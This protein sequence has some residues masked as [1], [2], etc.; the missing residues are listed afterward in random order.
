MALIEM[1]WQAP[2]TFAYG[3]SPGSKRLQTP[4]TYGI[5]PCLIST[6]PVLSFTWPKFFPGAIIETQ[7]QMS[8]LAPPAPPTPDVELGLQNAKPRAFFKI[9][10]ICIHAS[11]NPPLGHN[12]MLYRFC[13]I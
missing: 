1:F 8:L 4:S 3:S 12:T 10:Q 2:L 9:R 5:L 13:M 11:L 6:K 7:F